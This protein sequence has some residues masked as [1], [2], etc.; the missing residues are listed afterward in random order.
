[1]ILR[2]RL[3]HVVVQHFHVLELL[4]GEGGLYYKSDAYDRVSDWDAQRIKEQLA[5][6]LYRDDGLRRA[7]SR[8]V[9]PA[10][11]GCPCGEHVLLVCSRNTCSKCQADYTLSG[12]LTQGN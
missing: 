7:E 12:T 3:M 4:H 9:E 8:Y 1:M 5:T 10:V 11:L 6:G 2:A